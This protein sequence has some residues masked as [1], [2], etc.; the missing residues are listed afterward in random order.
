M[1]TNIALL[2][3]STIIF[4]GITNAKI[5]TNAWKAKVVRDN[6]TTE[7]IG[8][9]KGTVY[10]A[11]SSYASVDKQK[12]RSSFE[13]NNWHKMAAYKDIYQNTN[14]IR[15]SGWRKDGETNGTITF[16]YKKE[17]GDSL[18]TDK[19]DVDKNQKRRPYL[20]GS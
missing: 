6:I 3:I 4:S 18:P 8:L 11:N 5:V 14:H 15:S 13:I 7:V 19:N 1:K 12:M 10:R 16:I 2:V 17:K 20:L 9:G